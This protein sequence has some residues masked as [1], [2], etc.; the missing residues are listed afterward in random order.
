MGARAG[1][2]G[3]LCPGPAGLGCGTRFARTDRGG[4]CC[5]HL[6]TAAAFAV[7]PMLCFLLTGQD[8]LPSLRAFW[9]RGYEATSLFDLLD[10]MQILPASLYNAFGGKRALFLTVLRRH[11][12]IRKAETLALAT[13]FSPRQAILRFFRDAVTPVIDHGTRDGCFLTNT[14][15]EVA[16]H[17][18]EVAA[19]VREAFAHLEHTFFCQLIVQGQARGEIARSVR[20]AATARGL[21]GLFLGLRV[22]SR[23][24]PEKLLLQSIA[25]QAEALLPPGAQPA[26]SLASSR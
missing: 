23:S 7:F 9:S 14:A 4:P 24:R 13:T 3:G 17:D 21:L 26:R 19:I 18:A 1:P 6:L 5:D 15:L 10:R 22:L 11:A 20:P 12:A 25:H 2:F 16:P 8:F